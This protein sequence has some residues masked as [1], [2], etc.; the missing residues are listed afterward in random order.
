VLPRCVTCGL[1]VRSPNLYKCFFLGITG[2]SL[3]SFCKVAGKRVQKHLYSTA[4]SSWAPQANTCLK[5]W[6]VQYAQ[7]APAFAAFGF[8]RGNAG[9]CYSIGVRQFPSA[10]TIL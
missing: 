5:A 9:D 7:E 6:C 8:Q 4:W 3:I 1:L 10:L 2:A